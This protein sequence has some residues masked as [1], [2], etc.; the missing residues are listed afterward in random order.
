VEFTIALLVVAVVLIVLCAIAIPPLCCRTVK[1]ATLWEG[2]NRLIQWMLVIFMVIAL[3]RFEITFQEFG[4]EIPI[5]TEVLLTINRIPFWA[6]LRMLSIFSGATVFEV[7][8]FHLLR[9]EQRT[10]RKSKA[11][12]AAVSFLF[13]VGFTTSIVSLALPLLNLLNGLS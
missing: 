3:P 10:V 12:S 5:L 13:I 8:L 7:A 11:L 9:S 6:I 4:M 2:G 1:H